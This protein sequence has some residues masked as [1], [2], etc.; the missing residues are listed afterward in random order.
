[1][2]L[3]VVVGVAVPTASRAASPGVYIA[4]GDSIAAG[5]GSSLPR[6]RGYVALIE[7]RMQRV[8]GAQ[9][10]LANL[11]VPGETT[12][13]F[14]NGGQ[15]SRLQ[16]RVADS[17]AANVPVVAVTVSLG[18]NDILSLTGSDQAQRQAALDAFRTTYLS[19]LQSIRSTVGPD[20]PV[21]VTTYY[22]LSEGDAAIPN[23]D[24]WW[25]AQFNAVITDAAAQVSAIVADVAPA[26]AGHISEYT[27]KP[28][29]VHPTNA[30]HKAIADVVWKALAIDTDAPSISVISALTAT[31]STPTLQFTATDNDAIAHVEVTANE[32][33]A[34]APLDVGD[35]SYVVL[36]DFRGIAKSSIVVTIQAED[37]AGNVSSE[38]VEVAPAAGG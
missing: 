6:T 9:V 25:L 10:T 28:F 37:L 23:S 11:A 19:A 29:D 14:I 2:F 7:A 24:S 17:T 3:T 8:L 21:V 22:D 30:G 27:L 31:R 16:Q 1:M 13:S 5:T 36:L 4:L 18:G 26:F 35:G 33:I 34:N 20:V 38:T 15:L 12:A 32:G